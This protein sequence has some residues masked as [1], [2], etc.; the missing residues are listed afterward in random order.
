M[1]FRYFFGYVYHICLQDTFQS[2]LSLC[3]LC[4]AILLPMPLR[5]LRLTLQ[6]CFTSLRRMSKQGC[7]LALTHAYHSDTHTLL[8]VVQEEFTGPSGPPC[9]KAREHS[10]TK[11][12]WP[13][14]DVTTRFSARAWGEGVLC[15]RA[16]RVSLFSLRHTE[17]G[18]GTE[19]VL[20]CDQRPS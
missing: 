17:P 4:Q 9:E 5:H 1:H 6:S 8:G 18:A 15:L 2:T 13:S 3:L 14:R 16:Q 20:F 11:L 10:A 19:G 12:L 7:A